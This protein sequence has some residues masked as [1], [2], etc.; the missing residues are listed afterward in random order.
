MDANDRFWKPY[1]TQPHDPDQQIAELEDPESRPRLR[2]KAR[3]DN[4]KQMSETHDRKHKCTRCGKSRSRRYRPD[5]LLGPGE[6]PI[7]DICSR[8]ECAEYASKKNASDA[9]KK[10]ASDASKKDARDASNEKKLRPQLI[11]LEFHHYLHSGTSGNG[12]SSTIATALEL[13]GEEKSSR[14]ELPGEHPYTSN[15]GWRYF[16]TFGEQPAPKVNLYSK[17]T[18]VY[19]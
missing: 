4:L 1:Y 13:S 2:R 18:L 9:S 14:T 19:C 3:S 17:P 15:S 8:P 6:E 16:P 11:V 7:S 12:L 5:R 10:N